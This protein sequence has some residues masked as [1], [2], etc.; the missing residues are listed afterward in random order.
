MKEEDDLGMSKRLKILKIPAWYP[1]SEKPN[2]GIFVV[3]HAKAVALYHDVAVLCLPEVSRD[4]RFRFIASQE[5]GITTFRAFC[6]KFLLTG[7]SL[8]GR[9][10]AAFWAFRRVLKEGFRPHII[11]AHVYVAG[12]PA[13]FLGKLHNIPVVI[14]E[15]STAFP[16]NAIS[17]ISRIKAWLAMRYAKAVLPVSE[18]LKKSIEANRIMANFI[19]IPNPV[20]M[21]LFRPIECGKQLRNAGD[22][23]Q[24]LHISELNENK[25]L[26]YLF[27]SLSLLRKQRDDFCLTIIGDGPDRPK[28]EAMVREL[29]LSDIVE[30]LG[31]K[32]RLEIATL[33]RESD[34]LV[35][36]SIFETFSVV[37]VEAL[38]CKTGFSDYMWWA[39]GNT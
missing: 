22:K 33:L 16:R 36:P 6:P 3:D 32:S 21:S 11:H 9:Y 7:M 35:V 23:V 29:S 8:L 14:T 34:F 17:H 19:V 13:I 15:H 26:E 38:A 5:N 10:L 28:R 24:M 12:V 1:S 20:D 30:F 4:G 39:G 2:D 27:K 31:F 37:T 18:S 25:G